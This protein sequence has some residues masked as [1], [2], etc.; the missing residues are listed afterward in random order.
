MSSLPLRVW[1]EL[2]P[3]DIASPRMWIVFQ[4]STAL[5]LAFVLLNLSTPG[6]HILLHG[7]FVCMN[8]L[9]ELCPLG[10]GERGDPD[11]LCAGPFERAGGS[12]GGG[13]GGVD[14]VDQQKAAAGEG[15]GGAGVAGHGEGG[16]QVAAAGGGG[17]RGL[18]FSGFGAQEQARLDLERHAVVPGGVGEG[19]GEQLGLVEAAPALLAGMQGYGH[20]RHPQGDAGLGGD[21]RGHE[22]AEWPRDRLHA[23]VF[24]Q[25]DERAHG[26]AIEAVG[27]GAVEGGW[28]EAAGAAEPVAGSAVGG[29][30]GV[31]AEGFT[32]VEA[33]GAGLRG[34]VKPAGG[35]DGDAGEACERGGA[36]GAGG[37]E[38]GGAEGVG[39]TSEDADDGAPAGVRGHEPGVGSVEQ[40]RPA[41]ENAPRSGT[42][43]VA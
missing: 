38:N 26:A 1:T 7:D 25:V 4:C 21:L 34:Q 8:R 9:G 14:V 24:E 12:A 35:A 37:G 5:A 2:F 16:L 32:T 15:P 40:R 39:L 13:A 31:G 29:R 28:D 17:E 36:E 41:R 11:F 3:S 20:N 10:A 23:G 19:T 22:S 6:S 18:G 43:A 30:K 42:A 33:E 27:D